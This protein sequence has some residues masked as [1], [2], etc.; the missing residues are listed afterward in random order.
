M[1]ILKHP[2]FDAD[3]V[4]QT[5]HAEGF[6]R[7]VEASMAM[8]D[9]FEARLEGR[10]YDKADSLTR[11]LGEACLSYLDP[12]EPAPEVVREEGQILVRDRVA[13]LIDMVR[14]DC[15]LRDGVRAV[16][17]VLLWK[18]KPNHA[19]ME[20]LEL[21]RAVQGLYWL[22]RPFRLAI[23]VIHSDR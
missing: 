4:R 21:P 7:L 20:G 15:S 19:D 18:L 2:S 5:S 10:R 23:K 12:A 22:T 11:M 9:Y 17:K 6:G 1:T 8:P 14:W 16:V 13:Y 3:L